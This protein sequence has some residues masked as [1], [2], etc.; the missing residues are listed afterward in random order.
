MKAFD[1]WPKIA[2]IGNPNSGKSSLFNILTGLRQ[3]VANLPGVTVDVKKGTA[4]WD[5]N[6]FHIIDLPGIYSVYPNAA[7]EKIPIEILTNVHHHLHPDLVI[8][9]LDITQIERHFL[10]VTQIVDMGFNTIVALNMSDIA[11]ERGIQINTAQIQSYL[12]CPTLQISTRLHYGIEALQNQI[13]QSLSDVP[14]HDH[15]SL[16]SL[17]TEEECIVG[18]MDSFGNI[19]PYFK[20]LIAHH[21]KWLTHVS[22]KQFLDLESA[23]KQC[24][25]SDLQF[26]VH[27]TMERYNGFLPVLK[28]AVSPSKISENLTDQIDRVITHRFFGPVIFFAI[29]FLVFQAVF[30]W[31]TIPM[32]LIEKGFAFS[33]EFIGTILPNNWVGDLIVNGILSGLSGVLVFIPQIAILFFLIAVLEELGY[34][35]RVVFMFDGLMQKFGM[36]GRSII[37][38]ISSGACAI[39]A[40]MSTRTISNPKERLITILASPLISCSARLPVYA[41]LVGFVVP[42]SVKYWGFNAQGLVFS[43]LYLL[44][45]LGVLLLAYVS[46]LLIKSEGHSYLLMELPEYKQP[47]L[48]NIFTTVVQKVKSFITGAGKIIMVISIFLW[49][50]ASYGPKNSMLRAKESAK[51]E[52]LQK[53]MNEEDA[54]QLEKSKLLESSYIGHAGKWIEPAISPLGFD[55]KIGIALLTSFAAREVFVGTM[56]TLYSLGAENAEQTLRQKMSAELKP[57]GSR[58]YDTATAL[59][60]LIF[61]VFA[62]QCM[63]TLAI[64]RKETGTWKWPMIQFITMGAMAY[65]GALITYHIFA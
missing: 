49:I 24:G 17:S 51:T 15:S 4:E 60:L 7:D 21:Y 53:E 38:L 64:V 50:A 47:L 63:S 6:A 26:Q 39:P 54:L 31:A 36:N 58:R 65:F 42:S 5:G 55:W 10:L 16:Y 46:K 22:D 43:A 25:F 34:M 40:I 3:N 12:N 32:E 37:S 59:S 29:M 2:I 8:Y 18:K 28:S 62:L 57:D 35:S 33:A 61:Y 45:I 56:A 1:S 14:Q 52:A 11:A 41:V 19:S 23:A 27:E 44:G 9:V 20:K 48:K 13:N 30:A